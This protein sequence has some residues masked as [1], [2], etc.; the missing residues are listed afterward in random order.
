MSRTTKIF[1]ILVAIL[2][3]F[4]GIQ[5]PIESF[6]QLDSCDRY[7][8]LTDPLVEAHDRSIVFHDD[9][10]DQWNAGNYNNAMT[11]FQQSLDEH[12]LTLPIVQN[13]VSTFGSNARVSV[14]V[15][16][17]GP[18]WVE[19]V[20]RY[21]DFVEKRGE[22]RDAYNIGNVSDGMTLEDES[23]VSHNASNSLEMQ[24]FNLQDDVDIALCDVA[25]PEIFG[26][27]PATGFAGD[28]VTING[29]YFEDVLA[30]NSVSVGGL[31]AVLIASTPSSITMIVPNASG[32]S[33]PVIV[34]T[35][36]GDSNTV[37]FE[38]DSI[39]TP[40]SISDRDETEGFMVEQV[41]IFFVAGTSDADKDAFSAQ[42]NFRALQ[43]FPLIGFS[44]AIL[45]AS[46]SPQDTIDLLA[47]LNAD[48]RV[49]RAFLN[50]IMDLTQNEDPSYNNQGW[51]PEMGFE[52]LSDYFPDRGSNTTIAIID[53]GIDLGTQTVLDEVSMPD[54][55][56][57]GINFAGDRESNPEAN[58]PFGH[59][60]AVASI[61]GALFQNGINGTGVASSTNIIAM[62]VFER[63]SFGSTK[64]NSLWIAQAIATAYAMSAHVINLS[65]RDASITRID[66]EDLEAA[67]FYKRILDNLDAEIEI[68]NL[69]S[70]PVIV[71]ATG[72]DGNNM[73]GCPACDERIISVGSVFKND[74]GTWERSSFSNGGPNID[75]VAQGEDISTT[76]LEGEFGSAGS[77]TSFAAPQVAGLAALI[78]AEG[79]GLSAEQIEA[80]IFACFVLD[81]GAEGR[82][83]DTGR[84]RLYIPEFS[85]ASP[86]CQSPPQSED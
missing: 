47:Q 8:D 64:S 41:L 60:T 58:D 42:F 61:A 83:D 55:S 68:G 27:Q 37:I 28:I 52:N 86:E 17:M 74:D 63:T 25:F 19:A 6:G 39:A 4:S 33:A 10:F 71:A 16:Q 3:S 82:D 81:I 72:N 73:I 29:I 24:Y 45:T 77:G 15:N 75:M 65:I 30:N 32:P 1:T 79:V 46:T 76:L 7:R 34:T 21:E 59:G 70:R 57:T 31:D 85:S 53:T 18:L 56:P 69:P 22:A 44:R 2:I 38:I 50:Q 80:H 13:I 12:N 48:P 9:A 54:G 66:N 11:L 20:A 36:D 51:L 62:R 78:W 5:M 67:E 43:N 49:D 23:D 14:P 35:S 40:R 26:I 84:G